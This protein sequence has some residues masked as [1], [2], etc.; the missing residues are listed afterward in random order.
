MTWL[1]LVGGGEG[2]LSEQLALSTSQS[3]RIASLMMINCCYDII[4]GMTT[5]TM[6]MMM[7]MQVI[8][9]LISQL[10]N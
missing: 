10:I 7:M 2:L 8:N 6:A 9:E 4:I 1:L 3:N 5:T